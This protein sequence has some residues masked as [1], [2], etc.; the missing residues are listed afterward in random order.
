MNDSRMWC[1][2]MVWV[3]FLFFLYVSGHW[4]C[5]WVKFR[6]TRTWHLCEVSGTN[7]SWCLLECF[8]ETS[9]ANLEMNTPF[10]FS[11]CF[12][13]RWLDVSDVWGE[14]QCL[15]LMNE[16]HCDGHMHVYINCNLSP[17]KLHVVLVSNCLRRDDLWS[18]NNG[19]ISK[20]SRVQMEVIQPSQS[21]QC[22]LKPTLHYATDYTVH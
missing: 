6:H 13:C 7:F 1:D 2:V 9:A 12:K 18:C 15:C 4:R 10:F 16:L 8:N 20:H 21:L 14:T 5:N 17:K 3:Y 11:F 19:S 22:S